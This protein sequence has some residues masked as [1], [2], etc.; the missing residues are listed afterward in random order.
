MSIISFPTLDPQHSFKNKAS[1]VKKD[2]INVR[3]KY[4]K[5]LPVFDLPEISISPKIFQKF[6]YT[7]EVLKDRKVLDHKDKQY[8]GKVH[9]HILFT[10][11]FFHILILQK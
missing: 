3:I 6:D 8:Y 10:G 11:I 2:E 4:I 1:K 5:W 9:R 7:I